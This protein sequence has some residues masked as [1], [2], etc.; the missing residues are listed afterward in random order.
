VRVIPVAEN[1]KKG[2]LGDGRLGQHLDETPRGKI[3]FYERLENVGNTHTSEREIA[4]AG[5]IRHP[6]AAVDVNFDVLA[7]SLQIPDVDRAATQQP[8]ADGIVAP[9]SSID[10][11]I[12][13]R[14]T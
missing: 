8:K 9:R 4:R 10:F 11:G 2:G 1:T 3:V 14:A 7:I 13:A 5:W 6:H 12:P